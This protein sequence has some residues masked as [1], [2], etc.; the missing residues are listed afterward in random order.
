MSTIKFG[1]IKRLSNTSSEYLVTDI[2]HNT[3]LWC[4]FNP[5]TGTPVIANSYSVGTIIDLGVGKYIVRPDVF[6]AVNTASILLGHVVYARDNNLTAA[7][8]GFSGL[9]GSNAQARIGTW[10]PPSGA[11]I[12]A[13]YV[14][15]IG[16]YER[17]IK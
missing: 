12:D 6:T 4:A 16:A 14:S 3:K 1:S 13:R 17:I 10:H 2:V 11:F 15:V 5:S 8:T 9:A 7:N